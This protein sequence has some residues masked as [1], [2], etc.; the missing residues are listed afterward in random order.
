MMQRVLPGR[1]WLILPAAAILWGIYARFKGIGLWPLGVDEFYISRSI[2]FI[3]NTGIPQFPCGGVYQRGLIYQ[4]VV[5]LIRLTGLTPEFAGRLVTASASLLVLPAVYLIGRRLHG[6]TVAIL[7]A[8]ILSVS[9]WEI[10]MARFARMYAPFQAVFAWFVLYFIR[11]SVDRERRALIPMLVLSVVGS[12]VWEGGALMILIAMLAPLIQQR[13]GRLAG[14]DWVYLGSMG[15]LFAVLFVWSTTEWRLFSTIPSLPDDY[16]RPPRSVGAGH[17]SLLLATLPS[18]LVWLVAALAPLGFAAASARWIWSLRERWLAAVGLLLVLLAALTHQLLLATGVLVILLLTRVVEWP[19]LKSA[20]ARPYVIAVSMAAVFWLVYAW[21]T[22]PASGKPLALIYQLAGFPNVI[23]ELVRPWG[24]TLPVLT[25]AFGAAIA[26]L[27]AHVARHP[28][29]EAT[30]ASALV[31]VVVSMFLV[32]GA[33]SPPRH[34]TRYAFFLYPLLITLSIYAIA[35]LAEWIARGPRAAG[36]LTVA[37]SLAAF[38]VTGDFMPQHIAH[39]DSYDS[40]FRVG[41]RP[42]M[43]QHLYPRDDVKHVASWLLEHVKPGDMVVSGIPNIQPY[44]PDIDY[45]YLDEADDRYRNYACNRG[46]IERWSSLPLLYKS[47]ALAAEVSKHQRTFIVIYPSRYNDLAA[48]AD[49]LH[50]RTE[51]VRSSRDRG[52]IVMIVSAA[53]QP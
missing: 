53:S 36:I 41:M 20:R 33:S 31:L 27:I 8:V 39:I 10:E 45:F 23:D 32:I 14:R 2:D 12:L 18:H 42:A 44:Y 37:G 43:R 38:A 22:L 19:E 51:L 3:L 49:S 40:N 6:R 9:V 48:V 26:A 1:S 52:A 35:V 24:R 30:V 21:L 17:G 47:P 34:E 5:A 46:T 16:V 28:A 50:W 25:L 15:L 13:D 4:Y 29:K 11:Y 7:A